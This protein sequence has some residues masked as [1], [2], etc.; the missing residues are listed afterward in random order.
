MIQ[1]TRGN[2]ERIMLQEDVFLSGL[3]DKNAKAISD[4]VYSVGWLMIFLYIYTIGNF[5]TK[6]WKLKIKGN[7]Y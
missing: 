4:G 5:D 1:R 7:N 3:M 2:S 6:C